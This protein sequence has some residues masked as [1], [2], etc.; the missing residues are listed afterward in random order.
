MQEGIPSVSEIQSV[1]VISHDMETGRAGQE[2]LNADDPSFGVP[3][4]CPMSVL[5]VQMRARSS[6]KPF[7]RR[8]KTTQSHL[9][10]TGE[11]G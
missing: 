4:A 8:P 7:D 6:L 2:S 5:F 11:S 9:L 3:S 1:R 10:S